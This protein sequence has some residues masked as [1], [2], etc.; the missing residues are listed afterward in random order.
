MFQ[1]IPDYI[2]VTGRVKAWLEDP[3]KKLPV[4][5]TVFH[6][7]DS[8]EGK[9]GIE[10]SWLF[11]SHALRNAAGVAI[12]LSHIRPK[13]S[14]NSQGLVASGAVSF[15]T[16]YSHLNGL[17]RRG[18][19]YKNGAVTL[20]LD[21]QH[22]D[23]VEYLE[24]TS[25]DLPWAKRAVYINDAVLHSPHLDLLLQKVNDG[26]VWLAKK[27]YDAEG[28]R[29]YSNVCLEVL[30]PHRGTCLL[31]AIN[32]GKV[33]NLNDIP[34]MFE[35]GMEFLCE[36]HSRTGVGKD[37]HYLLPELDKQIGLGVIGLA[38]LLANFNVSYERFV[39]ALEFVLSMEHEGE[40]PYE[41]WDTAYDV[42]WQLYLGYRFAADV[43]L[44]Y[45]MKRAFAIAPTATMS[46]AHKDINGFTTTPEISPPI[47]REIDRDSST[48]GVQTYYY[49]DNVEIA[50]E[51]G[52]S[53]QWRL[54]CAWQRLQNAGGLAHAISANIWTS[55][56]VDKTF[57]MR[58][59]E[60]PLVTTYYRLQVDQMALD[61]TEV[62]TPDMDD[63]LVP[64]YDDFKIDEWE[65]ECECSG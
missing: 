7:E 56:T 3:T 37:G 17:L 61:K 55:V 18:G 14:Q 10:D 62:V 43:A 19:L 58:F 28:N 39:K 49:P 46:Y 24:A 53:T 60:S 16:V 36:L 13:G 2:T 40:R 26:T 41:S 35:E 15:A 31:S 45:D 63:K 9:D 57:L 38:N 64:V 21:V 5:C 59:L 25:E 54:L 11:T 22:P 23:I 34:Q 47:A 12:D 6:V 50:R 65:I 42:A 1:N 29:V 8:M 33:V 44:K 52:W 4:S 51:V 32:L 27:S 20:Y 30:L 48:F